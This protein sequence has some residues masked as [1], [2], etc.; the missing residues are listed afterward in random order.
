MSHKAVKESSVSL[1]SGYTSHSDLS[2]RA[3]SQSDNQNHRS[4][5]S[6]TDQECGRNTLTSGSNES[7]H[8]ENHPEEKR[9][10]DK[11]PYAVQEHRPPLCPNLKGHATTRSTPHLVSML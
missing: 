8:V 5:D 1:E 2:L 4:N 9:G 7:S 11:H 10:I 6:V 3:D